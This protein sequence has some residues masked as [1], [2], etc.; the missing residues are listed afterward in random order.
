MPYQNK[1]QSQ[2]QDKVLNKTL[3]SRRTALLIL[4]S[5]V[6]FTH[7]AMAQHFKGIAK[8]V[9]KAKQE[10]QQAWR[11][12]PQYQNYQQRDFTVQGDS[13]LGERAASRGLIYG[14]AVRQAAIAA[15]PALANLIAQE[16]NIIVPEWELKWDFLRPSLSEFDFTFA[17]ATAQFAQEN[18]LLLRGHT[19]V[20]HDAL[21]DWFAQQVNS[22][23]ARALFVEHIQTVASRYAGKMHSWDVVNEAIN[24]EDGHPDGLRTTPWLTFLG[25]EYIELAFQTAAEADPNA[26]LFYNDY[27]LD[28]DSLEAEAKRQSVLKLLK[29]LKDKGIPLHGLGIQAHLTGTETRFNAQKFK[30]FLEEVASLDLKILITEMD[31]ID[32]GLPRELEIRDRIIAGIYE[33][34]LSAALSHPAVIGILN[35]GISDRHTWI[36]DFFPRQDGEP[37]RSLPF[38]SQNKRKLAWNAIARALDNSAQHLNF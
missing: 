4:L 25:E 35:W 18:G 30:D 24:V 22:Q 3:I 8:A 9:H 1:T 26:L 20:W 36:S 12:Y 11:Q 2:V 19:L 7:A 33:D 31:V 10:N 34:Y 17:D 5:L 23:N 6:G 28:Y 29:R 38:D 14:A 13:T 32:D 15:E 21:P 27:D 37:V 16:C